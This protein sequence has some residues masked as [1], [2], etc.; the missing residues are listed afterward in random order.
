MK[1]RLITGVS[2]YLALMS[3]FALSPTLGAAESPPTLNPSELPTRQRPS[4]LL[5]K[6]GNRDADSTAVDAKGV[7]HR[8]P[9]LENVTK[10]V[11]PDYP[12]RD[13]ILRHEGNGLFQL[14]LDLKTG[15]VTRVTVIKS[16]GFPTLD[17]AAV[18]A[19]RQW[20]WKPGKWKEIEMALAFTLGV[21]RGTSRFPPKSVPLP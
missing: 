9:L 16:T 1:F 17:A 21:Y 2:V 5:T 18:V 15:L 8:V 14:T 11:A 4:G 6:S 3:H 7:R 19:L 12:D 20:R 13:R 10:H